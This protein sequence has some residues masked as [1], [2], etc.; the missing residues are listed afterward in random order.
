MSTFT[1]SLYKEIINEI[2]TQTLAR[3]GI[4]IFNLDT[5]SAYEESVKGTLNVFET[6]DKHKNNPRYYGYTFEELDVTERNIESAKHKRDERYITTDRMG[7][8]NHQITDVRKINRK[9]EILENYQHKVVKRTPDIFGKNNKYLENDRIIVPK[10][11]YLKHK[12]YLENMTKNAKD[13]K[14]RK[15][16]RDYSQKLEA[17]KIGRNEARKPR[18]TSIK[19]QSKVAIEHTIQTGLSDAVI[20]ALSTLA[21]GAIYEIKDILSQNGEKLSI[22]ERIKRLLKNVLDNF[23][24]TFKR[25]ASYGVLEVGIGILSQV[26]KSISSKIRSVWKSTRSAIK[27]VY[28]A[29]Y[30]YMIG[31]IKTYRELISII[32]KTLF[33]VAM[34]VGTT[35]L[36]A[37][38]EAFLTPLVTP[39][40]ASVLAPALVIVVG[41]IAIVIGMRAIDIALNA[42]FSIFSQH[43]LAKMKAEK[44]KEICAKLLPDL[45]AEKNELK[46][47]IEKTYQERKL[48]FE[49]SFAEFKNGLAESDINKVMRGL[50]SINSMYGKK[51]PFETF[52]EFDSFMCSNKSF[53]F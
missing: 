36:E 8:T 12:K 2:G 52:E 5:Y 15:V 11:D 26:F 48:S 51:L 6:Y 37:K 38:L 25:G 44:V 50:I 18:I 22:K 41:S 10:D 35:T 4:N 16:A 29:I 23:Y 33:T 3:F 24:K 53:K 39:V 40:V 9:G 28:D 42:L 7:E 27:Q 47:L 20:V 31:E 13:E 21:S 17:S 45:I 32:I 14:T 34:I 46:E 43:K 1:E 49:K 30:S 19:I